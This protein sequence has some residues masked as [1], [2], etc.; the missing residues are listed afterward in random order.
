MLRLTPFEVDS[1][2]GRKRERY[3][4]ILFTAASSVLA[5]GIAVVTT[6]ISVPLTLN[7]LGAER[8]GLWMVISS[9]IAMLG[10][11]DFGVGNG[12]MNAVANAYG[13]DDRALIRQHIINAFTVLGIIAAVT[14]FM[15]F[16]VY[17]FIPWYKVFNVT[18]PI[19]VAEAGPSVAVF[20]TCFAL[21][22]PAS[23]VIR[24]QMGLQKGFSANMWQAAGNILALLAV[25]SVIYFEGGLPWL[26]GTMI[27]VPLV[28]LL[29]NFIF[30]IYRNDYF[31][32]PMR[33]DWA[34]AK[35]LLRS[36]GLFFILQI[37]SI[38]ASQA[39]NLIIAQKLGA[40]AVATYA[41][42]FKLFALPGMLIGFLMGALW[43]A[44]T[45]AHS[46]GDSRWIRDSFIK[47][48]R[49][50][51]FINVPVTIVLVVFGQ[52]IIGKWVSHSVIPDMDLIVGLGLSACL[53]ILGGSFATLLNGLHVVKFQIITSVTMAIAK[54]G[55]SIQLVNMIGMAGVIYGSIISLTFFIYI[56]TALYIKKRVLC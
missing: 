46:R 5:K 50:S 49:Y 18:S 15:F 25:C 27:G 55:I 31:C 45:E 20:A 33:I 9:V 52:W 30:F 54:I 14:L 3:R 51:L 19:A 40:E 16:L 34:K 53:T 44:F 11:A 1:A 28:T 41:V 7:Y 10:F 29:A 32:M 36:S 37:S 39:D 21:N 48:L 4:R 8:Y 17:P 12:L 26:V 56:P 22:I 42:A 47:S 43:P 38:F 24:A 35:S 2:E 23:V 13:K 6:L